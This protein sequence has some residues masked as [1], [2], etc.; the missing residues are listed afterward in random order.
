MGEWIKSNC[1]RNDVLLDIS[2]GVFALEL[3]EAALH[4]KYKPTY[5]GFITYVKFEFSEGWMWK[6]RRKN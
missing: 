3:V 6:K 5:E 2:L 1:Y 4:Y